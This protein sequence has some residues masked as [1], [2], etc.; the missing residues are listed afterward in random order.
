MGII[1]VV[2]TVPGPCQKYGH[3]QHFVMDAGFGGRGSLV[4][5]ASSRLQNLIRPD[6]SPVVGQDGAKPKS[7]VSTVS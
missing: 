4:D 2:G 5:G 1:T 6:L 3:W 7:K